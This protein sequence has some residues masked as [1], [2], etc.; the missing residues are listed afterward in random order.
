MEGH[1]RGDQCALGV[2]DGA[3]EPEGAGAFAGRL[4]H[5]P[6]AGGVAEI[7]KQY[8]AGLARLD[9]P[10]GEAVSAALGERGDVRVRG[11]AADQGERQPLGRE[12]GAAVEGAQRRREIDPARH[13]HPEGVAIALRPA[14][15]RQQAVGRQRGGGY[16]QRPIA[17]TSPPFPCTT[18]P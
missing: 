17:H 2:A 6:A 13:L 9:G 18:P 10:S 15:P 3:A 5:Q 8:L 16:S 1:Q 12:G 14:Q 4:R 11:V 7:A